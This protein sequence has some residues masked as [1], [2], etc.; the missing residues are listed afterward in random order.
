MCLHSGG[1][2]HIEEALLPVGSGRAAA[3]VVLERHA[4]HAG[5]AEELPRGA[6]H[7]RRRELE[8]VVHHAGRVPAGVPVKEARG[9]TLQLTWNKLRW[10]RGRIGVSWAGRWL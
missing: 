8:D 1:E 7:L 6:E 4:G 2:A 5:A 9:D 3:A 10:R